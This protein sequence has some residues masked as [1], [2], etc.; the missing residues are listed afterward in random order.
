MSVPFSFS[1]S[2]V[3]NPY[4]TIEIIRTGLPGSDLRALS[5]LYANPKE[6]S[7]ILGITHNQFRNACRR[8]HLSKGLSEHIIQLRRLYELCVEAFEATESALDWLFSEIP[9]L[10]LARPIDFLDTHEGVGLIRSTIA[11]MQE[12][13]CS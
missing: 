2:D 8:K 9:V 4:R 10:G 3:S 12:G 11:R 5:G 13:A 7:K 1:E 6:V